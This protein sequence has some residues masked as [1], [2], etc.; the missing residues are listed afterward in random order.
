MDKAVLLVAQD[1]LSRLI[2]A[3]RH[4]YLILISAAAQLV[5]G[6]ST[7]RGTVTPQVQ[8]TKIVLGIDTGGN[9]QNAKETTG[10]I[11]MATN[12]TQSA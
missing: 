7:T 9:V 4:I 2:I 3:V 6:V 12:A 1:S 10:W 8:Q 5:Q 11:P